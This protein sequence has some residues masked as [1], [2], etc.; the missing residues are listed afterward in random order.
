MEEEEN[1]T[2]MWHQVRRCVLFS[3]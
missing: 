2:L 1:M 3:K